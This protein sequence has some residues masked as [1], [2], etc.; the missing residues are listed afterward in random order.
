MARPRSEG[1]RSAREGGTTR[2]EIERSDGLSAGDE[3]IDVEHRH[4]VRSVRQLATAL[5]TGRPEE[6]R[7]ALR[8]LHGHLSEHFENEEGWMAEVGY[9]EAREHARV[10]AALLDAIAG[11]RQQAIRQPHGIARAAAELGDALGEHMRTEDLELGRFMTCRKA[12]FRDSG[13][14][15]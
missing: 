4:I 13:T 8:F 12:R 6:I 9:P 10:H 1:H 3:R 2:M 7:G 5:A 11:A 15:D 14:R